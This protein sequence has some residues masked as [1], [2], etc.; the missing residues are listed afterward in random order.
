[1]VIPHGLWP[2][3]ID[4]VKQ[5]GPLLGVCIHN[6]YIMFHFT[7]L[8]KFD[9]CI[10]IQIHFTMHSYSDLYICMVVSL[11]ALKRCWYRFFFSWRFGIFV[12]LRLCTCYTILGIMDVENIWNVSSSYCLNKGIYIYIHTAM[13][14]CE[15]NA[16]T[17]LMYT[18]NTHYDKEW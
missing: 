10:C 18:Q 13:G 16:F 4:N 15:K 7:P 1:M 14:L 11:L 2:Y 9:R 12:S 3:C 8:D 5:M 17:Y 6:L